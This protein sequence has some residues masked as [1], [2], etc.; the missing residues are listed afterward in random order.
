MKKINLAFITILIL[1]LGVFNS[2]DK[3]DTEIENP[4]VGTWE[5]SESEDGYSFTL[6]IT[7]NS[8]NTGVVIEEYVED[9]STERYTEDFTYSTNDN[10]LLI[11][12][13]DETV[14][15]TYAISD[16]QLTITE[17]GEAALVFTRK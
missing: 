2:C 5:I 15:L 10:N 17:E 16:N 12:M 9:G 11:T 13:D 1:G 3:D 14:E 8:D 7:F 6:T 4:L